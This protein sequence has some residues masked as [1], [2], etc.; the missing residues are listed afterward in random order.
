[1]DDNVTGFIAAAIAIMFFGS[2]YLPV[3]Q[4]DTGDGIA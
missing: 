4:F 2:N 1:M 3:K